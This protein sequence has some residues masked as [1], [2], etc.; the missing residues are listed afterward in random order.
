VTS[1]HQAVERGHTEVVDLLLQA[2][3][4]LSIVDKE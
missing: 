1:L 4:S 3:S 2:G